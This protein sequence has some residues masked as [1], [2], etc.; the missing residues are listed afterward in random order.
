MRPLILSG[1]ILCFLAC[2][3]H[4]GARDQTIFDP[5]VTTLP[6]GLQYRILQEGNGREAVKGD[7]V[8]IRETARYRDGTVLYSN[9]QNNQSI[10]VVIGGHQ[11]TDGEDEG[12]RGMNEGEIR[13][14]II[15]PVLS[16]RTTYPPNLSPDSIIVV[17][18]ILEKIL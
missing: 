3:N 4:S 14:M 18:V 7:T 8:L 10:Q 9:E 13:E 5:D 1:I 2:H 16:R 17:K 12:L 11:A 15:P 6:S